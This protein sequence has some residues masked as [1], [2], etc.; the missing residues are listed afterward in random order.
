MLEKKKI[1]EEK[2]VFVFQGYLC[3]C[4]YLKGIFVFVFQGIFV[5]EKLI[6]C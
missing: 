4:I 1:T 6:L 5:N 2:L 3:L